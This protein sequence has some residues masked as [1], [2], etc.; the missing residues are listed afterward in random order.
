MKPT[1]PISSGVSLDEKHLRGEWRSLTEPE[2]TYRVY[3]RDH[4]IRPEYWGGYTRHNTLRREVYDNRG[5][6][7]DDQ[8]IAENHAVMMYDPLLGEAGAP[9]RS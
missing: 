8:F 2:F 3:E 1:G 7:I 4:C 6:K 5:G 9:V